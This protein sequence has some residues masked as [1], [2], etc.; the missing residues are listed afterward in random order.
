[1]AC[2]VDVGA[3]GCAGGSRWERRRTRGVAEGG[4]DVGG[5]RLC[6]AV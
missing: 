2:E 5:G 6:E 1:M 4:V 3:E